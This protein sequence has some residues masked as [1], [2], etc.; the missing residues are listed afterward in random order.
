M[1]AP[2]SDY[3]ANYFR[4][5]AKLVQQYGEKTILFQQA[6]CWFE[7]YGLLQPDGSVTGSAICDVAKIA[8]LKVGNRS[9]SDDV[10]M[11]GFQVV[12]R[13]KFVEKFTSAGYTV[14]IMPQNRDGPGAG[15][16]LE[17][18]VTPGSAFVNSDTELSR[19]TVCIWLEELNSRGS[20]KIACGFSAADIFTGE[21]ALG[22]FH[23]DY[24]QQSTTFDELERF[25][26]VYNP[27]E[28]IIIHNLS[29]D[30]VD[31]VIQFV[32]LNPRKMHIV[33]FS[34]QWKAQAVS[35]CQKQTYQEEV[36]AGLYPGRNMDVFFEPFRQHLVATCAFCYLLDFLRTANKQLTKELKE[37]RTITSRGRLVTANHS[38]IQLNIIDDGNHT[39]RDS[40]VVSCMD[41]CVTPMGSRALRRAIIS[42]TASP[43]PLNRHYDITGFAI[44]HPD[45]VD[46]IRRGLR[47]IRDMDKIN[48]RIAMETIAPSAFCVL[49][50]SV[51]DACSLSLDLQKHAE[52]QAYVSDSA[53]EYARIDRTCEHVTQFIERTLILDMCSDAE[54]L[55][56]GY[57][58]RGVDAEHDTLMDSI[59]ESQSIMESIREYFDRLCVQ[60]ESSGRRLGALVKLE[61]NDKSGYSLQTTGRR[62][63]FIQSAITSSRATEVTL[64]YESGPTNAA[65]NYVLHLTGIQ[66]NTAT[67]SKKLITS[68]QISQLFRGVTTS[69]DSLRRRVQYVYKLF[70]ASL[71]EQKIT[72]AISS[73]SDYASLVDMVQNRA[74]VAAR[75]K[76]CRPVIDM[77]CETSF[78]ECTGIRHPIIERINM[79]E[80]YVAN[81]LSIGRDASGMLI[82]GTNA[83]GKTSLMR[84][85]GVAVVMA[86]AGF[87]VPCT[88]F[89]YK[90][91][92]QIFTRIVGNDNMFKGLSSFAVEMSEFRT[93]LINADGNSLVLGDELCNGTESNSAASIF[94]VGMKHLHDKRCSFAFATHL[95]QIVDLPEVRTLTE[96]RLRMMHL[97]VRHDPSTGSLVYSRKLMPGPGSKTY[98]LEVC[99]ALDLPQDFLDEAMSFRERHFP[100]GNDTLTSRASR[101]NAAVIVGKCEGCGRAAEESHHMQQRSDADAK[102][103]IG[104]VHMNHAANIQPLCK[105]CHAKKTLSGVKERR[106]KNVDEAGFTVVIQEGFN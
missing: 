78:V 68:H 2:T 10:K 43:G 99:K 17:M 81:D 62:A 59:S 30:Q 6:G 8:E 27:V 34:D 60:S 79:R 98:G 39:G 47:D 71:S 72:D 86:Q 26:S 38:L 44:K 25:V 49:A 24:R 48:R 33:S 74:F 100:D 29:G 97:D 42:P 96:Q 67:Q 85:L 32:G 11:S 5:N 14:A 101:Y 93:I 19:H 23:A 57:I 58:Q 13:D 20:S 69:V 45:M 75:Y 54:H 95:H 64:R 92:T 77:E 102:G 56:P 55:V 90:P 94:V 40:S 73:V 52:L 35:N 36:L 3:I 12:F 83:V 103:Y 18:V 37:P 46:T 53:P 63:G 106:S 4:E 80:T 22:E 87:Y 50:Q 21:S 9:V 89:T 28:C 15:H 84:S 104:H 88:T 76:Y 16:Y 105:A 91:Y 1:A 7:M 65:K 61:R 51:Q 31:D 66:Y 41:H 82:Y 70:V